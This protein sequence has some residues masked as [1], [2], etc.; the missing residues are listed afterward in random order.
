[1]H[2]SRETINLE[3][4][5]KSPSYQQSPLTTTSLHLPKR[6]FPPTV[7]KHSRPLDDD[8]DAAAI[9][10]PL[11]RRNL[12]IPRPHHANHPHR[13]R[14]HTVHRP[15]YNPEP[16]CNKSQ[17]RRYH[18]GTLPSLSLSQ[19]HPNLGTFHLNRRSNNT[20]N[21][22]SNPSSSSPTNS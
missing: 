15:R 14:N 8:E 3:V 1:M 22:A 7:Q 19:K 16:A 20:Q 5:Q 11:F 12:E 9:V 17:H 10:H 4:F 13:P 2:T 18:H 6:I 21:R